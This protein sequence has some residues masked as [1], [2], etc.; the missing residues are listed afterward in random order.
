[1]IRRPPRSTL[2]PYTTLFRSVRVR[3]AGDVVPQVEIGIARAE[4]DGPFY[5]RHG[6]RGATGRDEAPRSSD[7]R[8]REVAIEGDGPVIR[9]KRRIEPLLQSENFGLDGLR[10]RRVGRDGRGARGRFVGTSQE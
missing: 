5:R 9:R 10:L 7:M 4:T 3:V 2:F 1:M 6:L 8:A